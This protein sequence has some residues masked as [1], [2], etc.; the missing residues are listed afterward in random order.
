MTQWPPHTGDTPPNP[1]DTLFVAIRGDAHDAFYASIKQIKNLNQSGGLF[2][3]TA[4]LMRNQLFMKELV[5]H[6]AD[7]A[8]TLE[9]VNSERAKIPRQRVYY[10]E[11]DEDYSIRYNSREDEQRYRDLSNISDTLQQF[12]K[13]YT[14]HL[15]P[16]EIVRNQ[17]R[18]LEEIEQMKREI[19]ELRG[20]KPLSKGSLPAPANLRKPP[21]P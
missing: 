12:Q 19:A 6:G 15:A 14:E 11:Y 7:I 8:Y 3:R 17:L 20:G 21:S 4:A 2:L 10:D 1:A 9:Q 13:H 5:S 18:I 16:I